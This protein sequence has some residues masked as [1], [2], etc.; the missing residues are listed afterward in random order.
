MPEKVKAFDISVLTDPRVYAQNRLPA[1]AAFEAYPDMEAFRLGES[2]GTNPHRLS[3]NGLWRFHHARNPEQILNGFQAEDYDC[4]SWESIRVPGHI[5]LQ[6]HGIPQYVN[7]KYPWDGHEQLE[8]GEIPQ[9]FNPVATYVRYFELPQDWQDTRVLIRFNGVESAYALWLNGTY[10]GYAT[11]TFTPSEF[12]LTESLK[13]GENKLAVQVFRFSV[14]SWT[15]DQDFFRFSGIY[16]DVE[17][18][19]VPETSLWDYT[20]RT[21]LSDDLTE[22]GVNVKLELETKEAATVKLRLLD[23]DGEFVTEDEADIEPDSGSAELTLNV[24]DPLLWSAEHPHLYQLEIE[25][26]DIDNTVVSYHAENV[27]IRRFELKDG[28]M[29]INGERIVFNGV[30]RH[31]FSAQHGRSVLLSDI[32]EDLL[33][34]KQHNINA[35]RTSHYPSRHELYRIADELGFYV[36]AENNLE[37]HGVWPDLRAGEPIEKALPG[38]REDWLD[39]MLDRVDSTYHRDKNRPSVLIWSIG[40]ESFG[41]SVI[42][43]M[44]DRFREHDDSR[45]VHYEGIFHD[46][47][48]NDSS[49]MESHMYTPVEGIKAFLK[50]H[51]EKPFIVCEYTHAMGNSIGGM[52]KYT[53]LADEEPLY[54]G[55]FIWDYIDQTLWTKDRF[56]KDYLGY[57]GD[58]QDR[59]HDG[60]FSGDGILFG[61][62]GITP[63]MQE[64]KANYSPLVITA[65]ESGFHVRNRSLFTDS[66]EY[67]CRVELA[68][69]GR[70][71]EY[72]E[73]ETDAAPGE[74]K[75]YEWPFEKR[76][77][78]GEYVLTVSFVLAEE[79][80]WADAGHEIAFGQAVYVVEA[81]RVNPLDHVSSGTI[82]KNTR[83]DSGLSELTGTRDLIVSMGLQTIGVK[84]LDFEALFTTDR[85]GLV[86]Y[87][88]GGVELLEDV[89]VPNYWRAP[90]DNDRGY[91]MPAQAGVWKL[92]SMYQRA[93]RPTVDRKDDGRVAVSYEYRLPTDP[94]TVC[95]VTYTVSIDGTI[96]VDQ[97]MDASAVNKL[98]PEF[99]M[100]FKLQADY[101]RFSWYGFGPDET[102]ADRKRGGKLDVYDKSVAENFANYPRPQESGAHQHVRWARI[103]NRQGRGLLFCS[104]PDGL[105]YDAAQGT[106]TTSEITGGL[107]FSA[108][109][110]TP[111]EIENARHHFE[112]PDPH[113]TVIRAASAQLGVAGDDTWGAEVHP[114]YRIDVSKPVKNSFSFR[115]VV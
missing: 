80:I 11:D 67:V 113:Y 28:L 114:E 81:A 56:G 68:C 98:L 50:E 62:H 35:I 33:L 22:A 6:G 111:H 71:L 100:L 64:V 10:I 65:D 63:K 27:G 91:N 101:D 24:T 79:H 108:L 47:R 55:G 59:P 43:K 60:N 96:R 104:N 34:M 8:I 32:V 48:Y 20:V 3:L 16:R 21:E 49:D 31:D 52:H 88:Y 109:H 82:V 77:A 110:Y 23:P 41:G 36:I 9:Q 15:E 85:N 44:A 30:N 97:E 58:F 78:P 66:G 112:L 13:A 26:L 93:G 106:D 76:K 94:E 89:V 1:R 102:Y 84:G 2:H 103:T 4:T 18:V 75:T 40:N 29:K 53:D 42:S 38:D 17:L 115:G 99:S 25:V 39:M 69:E 37:T 73:I 57:G 107:S 7:T 74:T 12:D 51:P 45:L 83:A 90:T 86:S 46:R 95:T 14:A 92:A 19:K 70:L 54:Q 87:N 105:T 72:A 5:Q 61:D